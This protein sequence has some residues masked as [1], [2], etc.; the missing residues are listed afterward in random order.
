MIHKLVGHQGVAKF[1][2][3]DPDDQGNPDPDQHRR[4]E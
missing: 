3:R 2:E 1:V 4:G